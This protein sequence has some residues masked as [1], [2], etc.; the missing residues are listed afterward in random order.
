MSKRTVNLLCIVLIVEV[1]LIILNAPSLI[2]FLM[3]SFV[4]FSD[5][6][7]LYRM[8]SL[9]F[10]LVVTIHIL[11]VRC[12]YHPGTYSRSEGAVSNNPKWMQYL[13]DDLPITKVSI[14]GTHDTMSDD[15][16]DI[17]DCQ[18]MHLRPQLDSGIRA[19]DIRL[20]LK[21]DGSLKL[22][23]ASVELDQT[24]RQVLNVVTDFFKANP[25]EFVIMRVKAEGAQD[26]GYDKDAFRTAIRDRYTDPKYASYLYLK[27]GIP[28]VGDVRSKIVIL[29]DHDGGGMFCYAFSRRERGCIRYEI[30][31][32]I[33]ISWI[34]S[35]ILQICSSDI[36]Q[37][38]SYS[39]S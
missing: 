4:V 11:C 2:L 27:N 12:D 26:A 30:V 33:Q 5:S 23:H 19:L 1:M 36:L 8:I 32:Y 38:R 7:T 31:Y 13:C 34:S 20:K 28:K 39:A 3:R 17:S 9:S 22:Y 16:N 24:F 10:I 18:T 14:P 37:N 29:R 21:N 15:S 25:S 6:F 35:D